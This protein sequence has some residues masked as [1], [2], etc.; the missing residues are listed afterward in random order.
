MFFVTSFIRWTVA[1][2]RGGVLGYQFL[3]HSGM[4]PLDAAGS[5][6]YTQQLARTE[7]PTKGWGSGTSKPRTAE[8]V[9]QIGHAKITQTDAFNYMSYHFLCKR[10]IRPARNEQFLVFFR[11]ETGESS[12]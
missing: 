4:Q 5:P 9:E 1:P 10:G 6:A 8:Q 2:D 3:A 12:D 11:S 7:T